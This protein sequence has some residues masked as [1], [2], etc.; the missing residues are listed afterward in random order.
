MLTADD[1]AYI[2]RLTRESSF[3]RTDF[4]ANLGPHG[5]GAVKEIL[6]LTPYGDVL[7]CPFM[8]IALGN[9]FEEAI[10]PIRARAL[11]NPYFAQYH[12]SCLVS[13]DA[14]FIDKYLSKTF[15]AKALPMPWRD[16]FGELSTPPDPASDSHAAGEKL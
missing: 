1:V 6:Y 15:A 7:A 4:Q 13:T 9:I 10:A 2:D 11:R 12:P 5:C 16:V 8:H 3:L 14:A